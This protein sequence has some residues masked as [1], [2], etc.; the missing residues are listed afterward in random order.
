MAYAG[1]YRMK[2][3]WQR[4]LRPVAG[5]LV[6]RH[7]SPDLLTGLAVVVAAV[8]GACLA[9]SDQSSSLLLAVP[10]L[11]ALRLILNL[12]DGQVARGAGTA[13]PMG[14]VWNELGDRVADVLMIGALAFVAAVGPLLAGAAAIAALLASYIGIT[15]RAIGGP[16]QYGGIMS[17]PGRMIVLAIAA[18]LAFATGSGWP[19]AAGAAVILVGALVTAVQRLAATTRS[20]ADVAR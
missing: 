15:S 4:L 19:L 12:L 18:P 3:A 1:L 14:E 10:V 2:P 8:A 20:L 6:G 5:W 7:V 11:A 13:S 16:R 17:K 9:L